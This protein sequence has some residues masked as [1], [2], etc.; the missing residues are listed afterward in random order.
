[1]TRSEYM[2]TLSG[3]LSGF[4]EDTKKDILLE[5]EDHIDEL[6]ASHPD[7][8][9][10][11]IVAG[12]EKPDILAASL[13]AEAGVGNA[14]EKKEEPR[15]GKVKITIGDKDIDADLGE[16]IRKAMDIARIFKE[17]PIFRNNS[18]D[19][20]NEGK[21][22][23][24]DNIPSDQVRKIIIKTASADVKIMLS[25]DRL[26]IK[27]L[28]DNSG[29]LRTTYDEGMLEISTR[30]AGRDL[31][32]LELRVPSTVESL[33][34]TTA[35]GN[36]KVLD[37]I[38]DMQV[39]T[40]SGDIII[41]ACSGDVEAHS[42]SGSIIVARCGE[43]VRFDTVSGDIRMDIDDQCCGAQISTTSGNVDIRYPEDF[44][45]DISWTTMSGEVECDCANMGNRRARIGSGTVPVQV[46]TLSG[47]IFL[48]KSR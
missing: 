38:G 36:V 28:G 24:L 32:M 5:I 1:M 21:S 16:V 23:H 18:D 46:R 17:T 22:I 41:E 7:M 31:D 13:R 15:K 9:E 47:D 44:D 10:E 35:S 8:M 20:S 14:S 2:Q 26:S 43:N 39:R 27:A 37:R 40:A 3:E 11:A 25:V 42:A 33:S 34:V 29:K 19:D 30:T 4:D 12:L 6:V 48:K 45:G